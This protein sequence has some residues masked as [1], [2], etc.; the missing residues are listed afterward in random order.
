MEFKVLKENLSKA[1]SICNKAI[2]VRAS[3][4]ILQNFCLANDNNRLKI[5]AT[6]LDKSITIWVGAKIKAGTDVTI[7]AKILYNYVSGIKDEKI[8]GIATKDSLELKTD[9]MK[10]NFT[11]AEVTEYPNTD[12]ALSDNFF[13]IPGEEL[14]KAVDLTF[15]AAATED[16]RPVM[17]GLHID[18]TDK[19]LNL[20]GT[21]G[22]RMSVKIIEAN[23][24]ILKKFE[25]TGLT[26]PAK[27]IFEFTRLL[28]GNEKVK[29]DIQKENNIVLFA[30]EDLHFTS[31]VLDEEYPNYKAIIPNE[32]DLDTLTINKESLLN[33]LRLSIVFVQEQGNPVRLNIR[34]S[35]QIITI[36]A[37]DSERG[38]N[39]VKV[40]IDCKKDIPDI[41]IAFNAKYL[42]D[43]LHNINT[44]DILMG[45]NDQNK[46]V[47]LRA[48][49][50][51][52]F[53]HV[54]VPLIPFWDKA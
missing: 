6:D 21:D 22:F 29:I 52:D 19:H 9:S 35:K 46:P 50:Q 37:S 20:V 15:F 4:P 31:K 38:Q 48:K 28:K 1:L 54:V 44:E 7:P 8:T 30:L 24:G 32:E 27:N 39:S 13:T 41:D 23:K 45:I 40:D 17:T 14:R 49:D 33:A 53:L 12:F 5:T 11:G 51:P 10:S 18:P 34:P 43:F 3:L 2:S 36:E 42:I 25:D 16:S 26:I 47:L